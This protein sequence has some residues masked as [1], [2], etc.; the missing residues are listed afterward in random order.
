[1]AW[2]RYLAPKGWKQAIADFRLLIADLAFQ[3]TISNQQSAILY[4]VGA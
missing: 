2:R 1:M 3:S 4:T